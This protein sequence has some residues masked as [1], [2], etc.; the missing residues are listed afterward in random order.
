MTNARHELP[1]L[2]AIIEKYGYKTVHIK[3]KQADLFW[4]FPQHES[5]N[6]DRIMNMKSIFN[7]LPGAGVG[8]NKKR[9]AK[10]FNRMEKHFEHDYDFVPKTYTLPQ[11]K[12]IIRQVL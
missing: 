4:Q 7:R 8:T 2:N 11:D 3:D 9:C 5:E 12:E 1:L 6:N 10:I